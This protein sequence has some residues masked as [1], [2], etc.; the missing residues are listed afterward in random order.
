MHTIT[1]DEKDIALCLVKVEQAAH[2]NRDEVRYLMSWCDRQQGFLWDDMNLQEILNVYR[3]SAGHRTWEEW[4]EEDQESA[5]SA[6]NRAVIYP[7]N[8][9][10]LNQGQPD[11]GNRLRGHDVQ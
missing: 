7:G 2:L 5:Y 11:N 8:K 9:L 1:L 10:A 3:V 6:W 4:V